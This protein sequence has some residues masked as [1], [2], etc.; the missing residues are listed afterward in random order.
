MMR[1][2]KREPVMVL[3]I[4]A[5]VI[6]LL[7]AYKVLSGIK[8][9]TENDLRSSLETVLNTTHDAVNI[10][11]AEVKKDALDWT[12]SNEFRS[13]V[14]EQLK[15][16]REREPLLKSSLL[17]KLD[18][19][20]E[21]K[22]KRH[23]YLGYI[24][25][26]PDY[27]NIASLLKKNIGAENI[28]KSH[29]NYLSRA[30]N[31]ET[32]V[33]LPQKT[34]IPLMD[35]E[36]KP[37][38]NAPTMFSI[39]PVYNN[40][41]EVIAVIAFRLDPI[42][43]FTP[44][45]QLGRIGNTGETY[46]FDSDGR[47]ISESR[48]DDQ[49]RSMG[50]I[51][52]GQ[53][54]ILSIEIKDPGVNLKEN[55]NPGVNFK[56]KPFT[57]MAKNAIEGKSRGSHTS[58]YRDYRGVTVVGAWLW[59]ENLGFGMVTEMD[60]EEAFHTFTEG[61]K[62]SIAILGVSILVTFI[63]F[64][65]IN[66]RR[67]EILVSEERFKR[68][69]LGSNDI[70]W[71]WDID[72]DVFWWSPRFYE[73][74]GFEDKRICSNAKKFK[75]LLHPDDVEEVYGSMLDHLSLDEPYEIEYRLKHYSGKY[76]W[77]HARGETLYDEKKKPV[78]L[79]GSIR[80][81]TEVKKAYSEIRKLTSAVEQSPLSIVIT[82]LDGNIEYVNSEF[83]KVTGYEPEEVFGKNPRILKS[84]THTPD[85]YKNQ[86]ETILSGKAWKG[87]MLN[88]SKE[89]VLFWESTSIAPIRDEQNKISHFVAVK[90]NITERKGIEDRLI[91]LSQ[92]VEQSLSSVMI[93][94]KNGIIKYVN[95]AFVGITGY[96]LDEAI[97]KSPSILKSGKH[98]KSFYKGIWDALLVGKS[99][100]GEIC[101]RNKNG[102]LYWEYECISPIKN[103]EGEINSYLSVRLDTTQRKVDEEKL[104][105]YSEELQRSN[106][107]L[108]H[109]ASIASHDL[110]EPLRKI[111]TFGDRLKDKATNLDAA[112][113]DY[114]SRMQQA[115]FRMR[116]LIE[117]ILSY[118]KVGSS[119]NQLGQ[120]DLGE[121]I[122]ESLVN[123]EGRIEDT[124]GVVE[125]GEVSVIEAD[126]VQM[127]L[128]FQN[129]IGNSLK[130]HRTSINPLVSISSESIEG[131][132]L[133]IIVKDNGIGMDMQ[134]ADK[135]FQPFQRL[136]GRSEYEGTGMGL[137]ICKKIIDGHQGSISVKSKLGEGSTFV[138]TLPK[139]QSQK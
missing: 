107:S 22:I 13:L 64:V 93:T 56:N 102:T 96:E 49:L 46:A 92:S 109:F 25:I 9:Q 84:G 133:R 82:N 76:L 95:P 113:Y 41:N 45:L 47:L 99:W 110:Q 69:T 124:G 79:S 50:L 43:N 100:E 39:S 1:I 101:N 128:M 38:P 18:T 134:F 31:G 36:N 35:A 24:L 30:F 7:L 87:I 81:I 106:E 42:K 40:Q 28:L 17:K 132:R 61:K 90:E 51:K 139:K 137:A 70:F 58:G 105:N 122:E 65:L 86:W 118:S 6:E 54:G 3:V 104:K 52:K 120:V 32:V 60:E 83:T 103:S 91:E 73:T 16:P 88:K 112:S 55:K 62:L 14:V 26:S 10:W 77:F 63:L 126:P 4:A 48:F 37:D 115:S 15:I 74:L 71:E 34:D 23:D 119:P 75:K 85:F 27:I 127:M 117:D 80:D 98:P 135:I 116:E 29:S 19:L 94:D 21:A 2:S 8:D 136:H 97:G 5:L 89:G 130:Y 66:N 138:I 12:E 111:I 53:R 121:I 67:K 33:T 57:L 11:I 78:K 114:I 131:D 72:K 123:L 44:I 68:S 129:L 125:I 20:I 59:D 108:G